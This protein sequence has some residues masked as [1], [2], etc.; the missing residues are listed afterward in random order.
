L[1][2][3]GEAAARDTERCVLPYA[4]TATSHRPCSIAAWACATWV[5][6]DDPPMIVPSKYFGLMRRY[7]ASVIGAKRD[8]VAAAKRPSTSESLSPASSSALTIAC[9]MRSIGLVLGATS[10]RSDSAAPTTATL[11]LLRLISRSPPG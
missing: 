5:M 1:Y 11:P 6:K 3:R 8:W 9:A 7:S 2:S 4:I 10:P